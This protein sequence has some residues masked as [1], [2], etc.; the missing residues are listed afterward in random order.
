MFFIQFNDDILIYNLLYN[1]SYI[2]KSIKILNFE[3]ISSI[4]QIPLSNNFSVY[5]NPMV[6]SYKICLDL[7]LNNIRKFYSFLHN[8]GNNVESKLWVGSLKHHDSCVARVDQHGGWWEI[9]ESYSGPR[10]LST[11]PLKNF[12]LFKITVS[13]FNF[14][15]KFFSG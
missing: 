10:H 13:V 11:I 3:F 6:F 4:L 12:H 9:I 14:C 8:Q 2:H 7:V 1:G 5:S 15:L